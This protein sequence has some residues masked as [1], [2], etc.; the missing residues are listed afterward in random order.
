MKQWST[1]ETKSQSEALINELKG[2][3][4]E[5][6]TAN[7]LAK[8]FGI[9]A[10][11]IS[12]IDPNYHA[13][14]AYYEQE[15]RSFDSGLREKL[16]YF[17]N[18]TKKELFEFLPTKTLQVLLLGKSQQLALKEHFQEADIA[19]IAENKEIPISL[20]FSQI[21]SLVN[22]KSGGVRT[23]IENYF[24]FDDAVKRQKELNHLLDQSFDQ[25]ARELYEIAGLEYTSGF[26]EKWKAAGFSELPGQLPEEYKKSLFAHYSRVIK[27]IHQIII[28]IFENNKELFL[29]SLLN[30]VGLGHPSL[31]QVICFHQKD[32]DG[33]YQLAKIE[34]NNLESWKDAIEK[35]KFKKLKEH[36]SFFDLDLGEKILQLRVKPMNI[37]TVPGLK[38]NC[39]VKTKK[40]R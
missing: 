33:I 29:N 13:Q 31:I 10:D 38:V 28:D 17:A 22:T 3:L 8:A 27:K 15:L 2:N 32:K 6:L 34:I 40:Q 5:F 11:F 16:P 24:D 25:M 20:K 14:L 26:D 7:E 35:L 36:V 12:S 18:M 4:F 1:L 39:S 9:E 19:L 21:G 23:F 37:F 30:L